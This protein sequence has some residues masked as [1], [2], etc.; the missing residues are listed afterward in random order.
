M[1]QPSLYRV[2]ARCALYGGVCARIL[3]RPRLPLES[4]ITEFA[5]E[6]ADC[7]CPHP[8]ACPRSGWVESSRYR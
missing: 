1:V 2:R 3:L 8:V 4:P 6:L 5:L 7:V